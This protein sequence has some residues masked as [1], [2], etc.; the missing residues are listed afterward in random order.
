MIEFLV[1]EIVRMLRILNAYPTRNRREMVMIDGLA[2]ALELTDKEKAAINWSE[3][4]TKDRLGTVT[5]WEPKATVNRELTKQQRKRICV[6]V[7]NPSEGEE[8]RR[9]GLELYNSI[10]SKLGGNTIGGDDDPE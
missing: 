4:P 1:I 6:Y 5:R 7:E 8:W 2:R 9:T 10:V 3:T